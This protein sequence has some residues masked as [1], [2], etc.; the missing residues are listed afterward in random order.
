MEQRPLIESRI[1]S[2]THALQ[3]DGVEDMGEAFDRELN[4]ISDAEP[5][6][7]VARQPAIP[8][9]RERSARRIVRQLNSMAC[10]NYSSPVLGE[11]G[12]GGET[13]HTQNISDDDS[14]GDE[15]HKL[16][17]TTASKML[18]SSMKNRH[19][20]GSNDG[21]YVSHSRKR[22]NGHFSRQG[23]YHPAKQVVS[24]MGAEDD[25][26]EQDDDES[27]NSGSGPRKRAKFV[28]PLYKKSQGS[29]NSDTQKK[30]RDSNSRSR[31]RKAKTGKDGDDDAAPDDVGRHF[32]EGEIPEELRDLDPRLIENIMCEVLQSKSNVSFDDIAGLSDVKKNIQEMVIWP[33]SRPDLFRGNRQPPRCVMLFGPPG[34]GKTMIAKAVAHHIHSKFFN[35]SASS[36]MSKWVG[37]GERLVKTLFR[38]ARYFGRSVIFID[39]ID[40]LLSKR[41]EGDMDSGVRRI[42]TEFLV[43]LDGAGTD[44]DKDQILFIGAT[45]LPWEIDE[46]VRRRFAKKIM[47]PLPDD[48][49]RANMVKQMK[50][51]GDEKYDLSQD[52][53]ETIVRET[54]G[55]S[56]SDMHNL[57]KE[58]VMNP[59]RE[60][61]QSIDDYTKIDTVDKDDIQ[62]VRLHDFHVAMRHI[63][64]SVGVE[65][66]KKFEDWNKD[67]GSTAGW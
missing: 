50:Q 41:T 26:D 4:N 28:S 59:L 22:R 10:N 53:I 37:E 51:K 54:E 62:P 36:L 33:M 61:M 46:A 67:H 40:S 24:L 30:D 49:A 25:N 14:S 35:I 15:R 58:A 65:D 12:N 60:L 63:R 9:S 18:N 52:D 48:V 17:F 66:V 42:K 55:Y 19:G 2:K 27:Y 43:G 64:A 39:E 47:V 7:Q 32:E 44:K 16:G 31:K 11:N 23:P 57:C 1:L 34:T 6:K 56:G 45:N 21:N 5:Y 3:T 8:V 20:S 38:L 29:D 13:R